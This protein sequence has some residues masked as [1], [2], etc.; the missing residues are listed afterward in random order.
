MKIDLKE[1][2]RKDMNW[3]YLAQDREKWWPRV[4]TIM[5]LPVRF[6]DDGCSK[7]L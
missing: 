1:I 2:T 4:N 6:L 3:T 5:N 7:Y